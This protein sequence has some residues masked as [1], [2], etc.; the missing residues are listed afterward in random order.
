MNSHAITFTGAKGGLGT[1]TLVALLALELE[2]ERTNTAP[3]V[4]LEHDDD[5][6]PIMGRPTL[7]LADQ[8]E[9][10]NP[11]NG[12]GS[13]ILIAS[14]IGERKAT[15]G[16][17]DSW[18][19]I[20][21]HL[22]LIATEE[23]PIVLIDCGTR[24][25][26]FGAMAVTVV[27]NDFLSMRRFINSAAPCDYLALI[28]EEPRALRRQDVENIAPSGLEIVATLPRSVELGRAVDSGTI[29]L[30]TPLKAR[31]RLERL[32]QLALAASWGARANS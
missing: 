1:S 13:R 11:D 31:G 8:L 30:R 27:A 22:E 21:E 20:R 24:P 15:T 18:D 6:A 9:H 14:N 5:I 12:H 29:G 28:E 19:G 7:S 25:A 10:Y 23:P 16:G 17:G 4:I 2:T 3:I 26:P 32:G